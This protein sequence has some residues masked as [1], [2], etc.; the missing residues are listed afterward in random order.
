MKQRLP[1]IIAIAV[2]SIL[3]I[4]AF[5]VFNPSSSPSAPS[6]V[7]GLK[8]GESRSLVQSNDVVTRRFNLKGVYNKKSLPSISKAVKTING[9][10][11]VSISSDMKSLSVTY[12]RGQVVSNQIIDA[13]AN[14]GYSA[15]NA[16]GESNIE[17][18]KFNI[19][20]Q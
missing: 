4:L 12:S 2:T 20:F 16:D 10:V 9:V 14:L 13:V 8:K 19:S 6:Q 15:T 18:L 5:N 17:V 7:L 11:G 1:V 3:T